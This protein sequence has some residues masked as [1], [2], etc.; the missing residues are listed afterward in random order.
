MH[1]A[2][3]EMSCPVA[4]SDPAAKMTVV[5]TQHYHKV[6]TEQAATFSACHKLK[7]SRVQM[8]CI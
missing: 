4:E 8:P 6:S 1:L 5:T 3:A 2:P 7:C